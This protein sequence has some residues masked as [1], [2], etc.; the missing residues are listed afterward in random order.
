MTER[1]TD[2]HVISD[3]TFEGVPFFMKVIGA[4]ERGRHQESGSRLIRGHVAEQDS[5]LTTFF[6]KAGLTLLGRTTTPEFALGISTE[7][8]LLGVTPNPWDLDVMSVGSM[9]GCSHCRTVLY[10]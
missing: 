6:K 4:G 7:S 10:Q 9:W 8:E 2:D 5:F 1:S 3:D